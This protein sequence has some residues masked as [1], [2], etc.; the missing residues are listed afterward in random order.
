MAMCRLKI[1]NQQKRET[2]FPKTKKKSSTFKVFGGSS[3]KY[4]KFYYEKV[5]MDDK[6]AEELWKV[7]S[8]KIEVWPIYMCQIKSETFVKFLKTTPRL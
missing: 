8:P 3:R 5:N 4:K 1:F 6:N 7:I 2:F